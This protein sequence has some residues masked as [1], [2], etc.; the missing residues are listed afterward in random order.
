MSSFTLHHLTVKTQSALAFDPGARLLAGFPAAEGWRR[1]HLTIAVEEA[2][3]ALP[4]A[5]GLPILQ[6]GDVSV[7]LDGDKAVLVSPRSR[8][9]VTP[10]GDRIDGLLTP[11]GARQPREVSETDLMIALSLALRPL[12]LHH[13]H[14]AGTVSPEGKVFLVAGTGGSGK[15]TLAAVMVS[16][17]HAFLGDDTVLVAPGS[18]LLAFPRPF[19]LSPTSAEAASVEAAPPHPSTGKGDLDAAAAFPGKFRWFAP[20]PDLVLLPRIVDAATSSLRAMGK[21]EALGAL[22]ALSAFATS[23]LPGGDEQRAR[24]AAIVDGARALHLDLGRDLLEDP[25]ATVARLEAELS[26]PA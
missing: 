25:E 20:E 4:P 2:P 26:A 10:R 23:P 17:G 8:L 11:E 15:S 6:H 24:L 12:G 1:P 21:S 5:H 9:V 18:T 3:G 19:H 7:H 22:L 14:A 13:L 16:A